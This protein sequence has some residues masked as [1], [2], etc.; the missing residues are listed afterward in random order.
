M[1]GDEIQ[2]RDISE[3]PH[4]FVIETMELFKDLPET[5]KAKVHFIHMN[6]TNPLLDPNSAQT[7]AV[8]K[9]G[10]NI[11]RFGRFY[12]IVIYRTIDPGSIPP[13]GSTNTNLPSVF[14]AINNMPFDSTPRILRGSQVGDNYCL[15]AY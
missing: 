8:L 14:S 3:I 11:A 10:F 15:L 4:P 1:T 13:T 7:K 6:H 12:K 9:A 5:E 2:S